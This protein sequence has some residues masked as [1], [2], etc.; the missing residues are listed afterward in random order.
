MSLDAPHLSTALPIP[1]LVGSDPLLRLLEVSLSIEV[2][3]A[4]KPDF[5]I[6]VGCTLILNPPTMKG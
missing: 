4:T 3:D 1:A 6:L 2:V 5:P